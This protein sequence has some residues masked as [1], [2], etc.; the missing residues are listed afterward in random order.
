MKKNAGCLAFWAKR[1]IIMRMSTNQSVIIWVTINRTINL[2]VT[3]R[4]L[5]MEFVM[6]PIS[7]ET[8]QTSN[9]I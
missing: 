6:M 8:Y 4:Q 5:V 3:I 1:V 7:I 2:M 9:Q